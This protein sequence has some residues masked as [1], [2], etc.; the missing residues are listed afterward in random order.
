MLLSVAWRL[1][2]RPPAA[3]A[4]RAERLR[5]LRGVYLKTLALAALPLAAIAISGA[6]TGVWLALGIGALVWLQEFA[7]LLLQL[8][9]ERG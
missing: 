4:P 6:S 9:R 1:V 8:R 2:G 5:W 7:T 3:G